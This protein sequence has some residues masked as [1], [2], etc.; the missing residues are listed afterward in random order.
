MKMIDI[1][2]L[3]KAVV[4]VSLF[5][6]SFQQ[7]MGVLN[8]RGSKNLTIEKAR[9]LLSFGSYF[10]YLYGRVMKVD[11]S[12]DTLDPWLY[13]R[14]NGAGSAEEIINDIRKFQTKDDPNA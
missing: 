10:D 12:G 13:D 1:K 3:D 4:L 2:G 5:N 7:G 11:L 14:D 9:E 6:G 8:D